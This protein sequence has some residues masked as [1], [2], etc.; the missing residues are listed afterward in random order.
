LA[1]SLVPSFDGDVHDAAASAYESC[2]DQ[3]F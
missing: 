1:E 2:R 3:E